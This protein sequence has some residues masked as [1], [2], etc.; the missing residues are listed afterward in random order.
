[1]AFANQWWR[2]L[3]GDGIS[4]E[5]DGIFL[6]IFDGLG[7]KSAAWV[8]DRWLGFADRWLGWWVWWPLLAP[9]S[10]MVYVCMALLMIWWFVFVFVCVWLCWWFDD[11]CFCVCVVM[12][13]DR[14][15]GV[16]WFCVCVCGPV[17]WNSARGWGRKR[18]K[19]MTIGK[20]RKMWRIMPSLKKSDSWREIIKKD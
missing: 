3:I 20:P 11:L 1:M 17:C 9:T 10:L 13:L 18:G 15:I 7:F 6:G 16:S 5:G 12:G 2:L 14:L 8:S 4:H 19:K